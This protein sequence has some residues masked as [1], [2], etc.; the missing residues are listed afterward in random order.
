MIQAPSDCRWLLLF[1]KLEEPATFFTIS[2]YM[3][4]LGFQKRV[5]FRPSQ[6]DVESLQKRL[7][8][9]VMDKSETLNP[10]IFGTNISNSMNTNVTT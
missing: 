3:C 2:R 4:S 7:H 9:L 10:M 5:H 1:G 6:P 8:V